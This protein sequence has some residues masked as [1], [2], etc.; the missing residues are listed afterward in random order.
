MT[1]REEIEFIVLPAIFRAIGPGDDVVVS[2]EKLLAWRDAAVAEAKQDGAN[3]VLANISTP[4]LASAIATAEKI[5]ALVPAL[6]QLKKIG[7]RRRKKLYADYIDDD[8]INA[9]LAQ[10]SEGDK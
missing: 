3:A 4:E 1:S 7:E 2:T 9:Q 6:R 8:S 10:P 5:A